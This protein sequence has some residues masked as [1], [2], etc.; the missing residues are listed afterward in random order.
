VAD[1]FCGS[2][3][4]PLVAARNERRFIA[5]DRTWRAIHTARNRLAGSA[6]RPFTL[7]RESGRSI[8]ACEGVFSWESGPTSLSL[9]PNSF[10]PVDLQLDYWEIDPDWN[11]TTFHSAFQACRPIRG[12][13]IPLQIKMPAAAANAC[14]RAI[15][16]H[17]EQIQLHV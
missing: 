3:T 7:Y 1:F 10:Q 9:L 2:G 16:I 12:G 8:P 13:E 14:I 17:G 11:G 6:E 4:F 5:S 15:T